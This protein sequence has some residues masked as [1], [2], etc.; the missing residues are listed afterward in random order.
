M[1]P[2]DRSLPPKYRVDTMRFRALGIGSRESVMDN[3]DADPV[4]VERRERVVWLTLNRPKRMNAVNQALY[5]QLT[6]AVRAADRDP[7]VRVIVLTGSGRAFCAGADLKAHAETDRT[8]RER[9]QYARNAQ[10]ANLALQRCTKPVV[11]AVNG[12]AI[13]AGLELALSCDFIIV[14]ADAKLRFPELALGTFVGGGVTYTLPERVGMARARE[15]LLL[16]EFFSG[17]QAAAL[18]L[19]NR[20]VDGTRVAELVTVLASRLASQAPVPVRLLKRLLRRGRRWSRREIL[21][22]EARALAE[23][24]A[25]DDWQ[26]GLIAFGEKRPALYRGH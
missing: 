11:A 14:A 16:G 13:G 1:I 7:E 24:M 6:A 17:E 22:A 25:T 3:G 5:E 9:R 18:G 2:D 8:N 19:A 4:L 10:R 15:L 23:C 21:A 20:A 26:E 12:P